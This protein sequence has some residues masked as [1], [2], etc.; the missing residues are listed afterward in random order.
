MKHYVQGIDYSHYKPTLRQYGQDNNFMHTLEAV[1]IYPTELQ[2]Q[3]Q[4]RIKPLISAI[5]YQ[6]QQ[7]VA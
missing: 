4:H 5:A 6:F 3:L 2:A 7:V 1:Y